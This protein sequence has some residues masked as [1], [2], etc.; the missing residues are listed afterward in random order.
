MPCFAFPGGDRLHRVEAE[1]GHVGDRPDRPPAVDGAYG[2]RGILDERQ[3]EL[4]TY[5][6]YPVGVHVHASEV[7]RDDGLRPLADPL[8]DGLRGDVPG[9]RVYVGEHG[10]A[11]AV[12]HAV[13]R[14]GE[15]DRGHDDLVAGADPRGEARDV[16]RGGAV[17]DRGGV[18]RAG[19]LR[20][21]PLEALGGGAAG[22]EVAPEHVGDRGDVVLVD[23]LAAVP[24]QPLARGGA[25]VHGQLL[26][27]APPST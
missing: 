9:P 20:D 12:E 14:R 10:G 6:A 13:G 16:Q 24:Q 26:H 15:R 25:A 4:V 27:P 23:R 18:P 22:Q 5:L 1:G 8:A 17:G 21:G 11:A 2:V 19:G 3:A 7:D